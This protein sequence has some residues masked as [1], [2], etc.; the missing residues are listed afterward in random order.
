MWLVFNPP[1]D[2]IELNRFY[3]FSESQSNVDDPNDAASGLYIFPCV[4]KRAH[5]KCVMLATP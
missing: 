1:K 4:L 5:P 3:L 2:E